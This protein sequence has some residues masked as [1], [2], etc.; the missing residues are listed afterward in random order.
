MAKISRPQAAKRLGQDDPRPASVRKCADRSDSSGFI[1]R[2]AVELGEIRRS[3]A[4]QS[5]ANDSMERV[6]APAGEAAGSIALDREEAHHLVRV[7]RVAV[8]DTVIAFDG[9]GTSWRCRL[10]DSGKNAAWL[11]VIERVDPDPLAASMPEVW[12]GTAVPKGD[13]FDWIVEKA[14]ELGIR[15]IVPLV[16]QRSVVE[17]RATKLARLRRTVV[18]ACKQCGRDQLAEITEPVAIQDYL[19]NRVD[20]EVRAFADRGPANLAEIAATTPWPQCVRVCVGP[21]GGWT[22]PERALA[23]ELGW[24]TVGLGPH[25]L[26]IET[27]AIAAA[28]AIWQAFSRDPASGS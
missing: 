18:E 10:A 23:R 4:R 2:M 28:A 17:P 16:C 19:A 12:L 21:E 13:R 22:D 11:E 5:G 6:Y 14:T 8:G 27:A 3:R 9:Q 24:R 25:I 15:R 26:R 1:G 7:R 20:G